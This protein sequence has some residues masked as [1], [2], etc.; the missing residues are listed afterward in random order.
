[1]ESASL[2]V[3]RVSPRDE[4]ILEAVVDL[5]D[6]NR[7]TLGLMP[8][9]VF[10]DLAGQGCL[11]AAEDERGLVAGYAMFALARGRVR[12]IHLC[13]SE[14]HRR[15]GVAAALVRKISA[16]HPDTAGIVLKCRRDYD[17]TAAWPALGFETKNEV[18]GRGKDRAPLMVWWRSHNLPDL[19]NTE[20]SDDE[21]IVVAIDHNVFIDLAV[22]PEREGARESQLLQADWLAGQI[23]LKLTH[24]SSNEINRL[25]DESGRKRQRAALSKFQA[26][27]YDAAHEDEVRDSWRAT[28]GRVDPE[29][30]SDCN[31]II[32]AAAGGAR[33]FVT[34]DDTLIRRFAEPAN[35]LFGLRIMR[36]SE[37]I[38]HLDEIA[39]ADRYRPVDLHGTSYTVSAWGIGAAAALG[40]FLDMPSGE[41]RVDYRR[42]L[43]QIA[44]DP[45][46]EQFSVRDPKEKALAAWA[47]KAN[48][49]ESVLEVPYLRVRPSLA[50][51]STFAR[52][53]THL[54]RRMALER[55]L[56]AVRVSDAHASGVVRAALSEDGFVSL[57]RAHVAGVLDVR[58]THALLASAANHLLGDRIRL[59]VSA[60]SGSPHVVLDL[61]RSLWPAKLLDT[62]MPNYIVPIRRQWAS[63]LLGFDD[64]LVQRSAPLGISREHVYYRSPRLNPTSP[65]RLAWYVSD[66]SPRGVG[67][68]VAVSHLTAVDVDTPE[69]LYRRYQR[70]GVYSR[71]DILH[72]ARDGVATALRFVDTEILRHHL[73]YE[74]LRRMAPDRRLPTLQ[75]P[76]MINSTL[77]GMIYRSG[78]GREGA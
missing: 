20:A 30:S 25:S 37:V 38:T 66:T 19:L 67:A 22:D 3:K 76:T 7:A 36:P 64:A 52:V 8:R 33:V 71:R 51:A 41:R 35:D 65:A 56:T 27:E 31:H 75:S 14:A 58:S 28:V 53:I 40:E 62:D 2:T 60:V 24:E 12:L 61:E 6:K 50:V 43:Q 45:D 10:S 59:A 69:D 26:L 73:P 47:V 1:M 18:P 54:L 23:V 21:A 9:S 4:E 42:L 77:F 32:S 48:P 72:I 78:T 5:A 17:A 11:L 34:R 29:D 46:V 44:A 15:R 39:N 13:V 55:S 68:I 74:E 63:E 49:R 16:S 70:L 57:D